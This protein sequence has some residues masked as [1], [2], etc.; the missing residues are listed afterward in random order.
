MEVTAAT[1]PDNWSISVK[2]VGAEEP[3]LLSVSPDDCVRELYDQIESATGVKA[4]QQRLIYRGRLIESEELQIKDIAGLDDGHTIH[5]VRKREEAEASQEEEPA[6]AAPADTTNSDSSVSGSSNSLLAALMG[7][8]ADEGETNES[9]LLRASRLTNTRRTHYRLSSEDLQVPDPGSM[10]HVRQGLMTLHTLSNP[11]QWY[12]GQWIDCRDTV[13]QWLEATIVEIMLPQDILSQAELELQPPAQPLEP[14]TDPVVTAS[15]LEGRRRLL[16]DE[17]DRPRAPAQILLIHYNGWP[18]RWDEWVRSD[19]ERIRPFRVRTRHPTSNSSALPTPQSTYADAPPTFIGRPSRTSESADDGV[20]N[21]SIAENERLALLPELQRV[22]QMVQQVLDESAEICAQQPRGGAAHLPWEDVSSSPEENGALAEE[23]GQRTRLD[24]VNEATEEVF[25]DAKQSADDSNG[26][27][28]LH[29][30]SAMEL[31]D[32]EEEEAETRSSRSHEQL[33]EKKRE[34]KAIASK[35]QDPRVSDGT[36]R[37]QLETLAPLLDRLGRTLVDSAPHVAALAA[38]LPS[39]QIGSPVP[40]A[41]LEENTNTSTLGGLLSLLNRRH[42][43]EQEEET[44][45]R[46]THPSNMAVSGS[47]AE[48]TTANDEGTTDESA[49][50]HSEPDYSDFSAGVVNTTRGVVRSGP[51]RRGAQSEDVSGLLGAYLAAAS[52]ASIAGGDD[53]GD[54]GIG[55][56]LRERGAGGGGIDIH[57]HAVV[58]SPGQGTLGIL[59]PLGSPAAG[60]TAT[61]P[62]IATNSSNTSHSAFGSLFRDRRSSH[63]SQSPAISPSEEDMGIFA[64]LYSETPGPVDLNT[65]PDERNVSPQGEEPTRSASFSNTRRSRRPNMFR[66]LFRRGNSTR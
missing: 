50:L 58:T 36:L 3:L 23:D 66:R 18:H 8:N 47:V 39:E 57:V 54:T 48:E 4:K 22:A 6:S 55:R 19:S 51:R 35:Q 38:S 59:T 5:L 17:H 12:L 32:V 21:T 13:N 28:S 14:T 49:G 41:S 44:N 43:N 16:F 9:R 46:I 20:D 11:R 33:E 1:P 52:L 42:N 10:E 61:A 60:A 65:S 53:D 62:A 24:L 56:L 25:N 2:T 64:E 63:N 7:V 29:Q 15:D 27:F 26:E 37:R 45:S 40:S 31:S 34:G 30:H